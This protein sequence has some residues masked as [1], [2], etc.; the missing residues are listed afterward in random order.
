VDGEREGRG[1]KLAELLLE[2]EGADGTWV[3]SE[4][5]VGALHSVGDVVVLSDADSSSSASFHGLFHV[6]DGSERNE[7]ENEKNEYCSIEKS[8]V[9]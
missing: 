6:N 8:S 1:N 2:A 4:R 9:G 7:N 3:V 5:V